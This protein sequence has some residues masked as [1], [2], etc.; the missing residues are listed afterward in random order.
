MKNRLKVVMTVFAVFLFAAATAH[1]HTP[2]LY[3]EDLKDG[4]V[5]LEGGF[6][7]GSSAAGVKIYLVEDS[8]FKGNTQVRD[9]YLE[10]IFANAPLE[11]A[12]YLKKQDSKIDVQAKGFSYSDLAPELFEKKLIIFQSQ[13][14]EYGELVLRKPEGKYLIVFD[15]G[16]GHVVIKQGPVLTDAEKNAFK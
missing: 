1:A 11:K 8:V 15:A 9:K 12:A 5:Y 2:I 4:T 3:V 7:D 6:S 16:P 10:A 13:L 14:D